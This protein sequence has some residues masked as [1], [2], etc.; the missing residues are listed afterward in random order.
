[1]DDFA[2]FLLSSKYL[3]PEQREYN[4]KKEQ[5]KDEGDNGT[6]RAH[7]WNYQVAEARPSAEQSDYQVI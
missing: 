5:E 4:E 2:I 3:H 7:Q 6:E 1:M